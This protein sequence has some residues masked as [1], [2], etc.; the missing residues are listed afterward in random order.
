MGGDCDKQIAA[1]DDADDDNVDDVN[2]N[3]KLA[4]W[5]RWSGGRD[6]MARVNIY[7]INPKYYLCLIAFECGQLF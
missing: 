6:T 5:R 7:S 1:I 2:D 4:G 3:C